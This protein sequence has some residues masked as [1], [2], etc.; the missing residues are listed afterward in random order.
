M[1]TEHSDY[2]E[3]SINKEDDEPPDHIDED[4]A[5]L[6]KNNY[7]QDG[8]EEGVY[9]E[10]IFDENNNNNVPKAVTEKSL[11]IQVIKIKKGKHCPLDCHSPYIFF[12]FII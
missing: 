4:Q 1:P 5:L 9:S 6:E 12:L 10:F 8:D 3:L 11:A 7:N 2:I